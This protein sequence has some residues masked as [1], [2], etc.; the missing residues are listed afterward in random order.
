MIAVIVLIAVVAI[1]GWYGRGE[2]NIQGEDKSAFASEE[3]DAEEVRVAVKSRA[4]VRV[5]MG[6]RR[7]CRWIQNSAGNTECEGRGERSVDGGDG[8]ISSRSIL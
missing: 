4:Q 2:G 8:E 7:S 3:V 6:I 1:V 5:R